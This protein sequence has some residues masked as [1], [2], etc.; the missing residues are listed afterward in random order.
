VT[1]TDRPI[2]TYGSLF[3]GVGGFDMGFDQ[4]GF[5]CVFQV[6]KDED[7]LQVLSHHWSDVPKWDDICQV[8][9]HELPPCDILI[10][11][12]PCQ[13]ISK[14]GKA[15]G[16]EGTKSALFFEALRVIREMQDATNGT[17]PR[18]VVWE[19]VANAI[20]SNQG[21][22]FAT[23]IDEMAAI[24]T[25]AIEW[26][27][28]DAQHFGIAQR[29]RRLFATFVIDPDFGSRCP[30]Q[31]FPIQQ[32]DHRCG[33]QGRVSISKDSEDFDDLDESLVLAFDSNFGGFARFQN[34]IAPT[35]KVGGQFVGNPPA[36][37]RFGERPRKL[38]PIEC[39]RLMGWP[40]NHTLHRADGTTSTDQARYRMCGNGVVAP[41]A[42]WIAKHIEQAFFTE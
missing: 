1:K 18:I 24:G 38:L 28:L 15:T 23:I 3:S 12:S 9:G 32:S 42:A 4:A 19:N 10:F 39:E 7:C 41:V 25:M 33:A 5:R 13:D 29:R 21:S 30:N 27:I 36:I 11:G 8:S 20:R 16:L 22:D 31:I 14:V 2:A 37:V 6:E 35:L 40:D 34:N 17:F 26:H